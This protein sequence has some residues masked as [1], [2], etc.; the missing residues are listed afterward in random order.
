[1]S[2]GRVLVFL[3]I[4]PL[5][6]SVPIAKIDNAA[7]NPQSTSYWLGEFGTVNSSDDC[8]CRCYQNA[9]CVT[10][11]YYGFNQT[12]QLFSAP[13]LLEYVRSVSAAQLASIISFSNLSDV[14]K[15]LS[16]SLKRFTFQ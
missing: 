5:S 12:C 7:F 11:S 3:V 14:G 4:S 9:S 2:V 16:N 10:I 8:V 13:L 6:L 15:L 1:M